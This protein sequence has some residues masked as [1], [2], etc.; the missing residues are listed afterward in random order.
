LYVPDGDYSATGVLRLLH[1]VKK[2]RGGLPGTSTDRITTFCSEGDVSGVDILTVAF[3]EH[4][5]TF[6][7]GIIV[8]PGTVE[9]MFQLLADE[10]A[11]EVLGPFKSTD[12]NMHTMESRLMVVYTLPLAWVIDCWEWM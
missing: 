2:F 6:T 3:D 4:R 10:P 7:V 12:A 1:S 11:K 5:L 8:P 9:R